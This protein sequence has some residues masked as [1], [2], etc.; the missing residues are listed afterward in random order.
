MANRLVGRCVHHNLRVHRDRE[1]HRIARAFLTV[2]RVCRSDLDVGCLGRGGL[3]RQRQCAD[4][5][6]T[7]GRQIADV[8]VVARPCI[9]HRTVRDGGRE[10]NG[11][12]CRIVADHLVGRCVHHNGRIHRDVLNL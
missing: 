4:V 7:V 10:V 12:N 5:T 9:T 8:R 11:F 3:V 6:R 2:V 1:G